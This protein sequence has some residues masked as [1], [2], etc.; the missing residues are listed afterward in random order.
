M[1][2][3]KIHAVVKETALDR[4]KER[5]QQMHVHNL[6]VAHVKGYGEHD[7]FFAFQSSHRYAWIEV[8]CE[9]PRADTIAQAVMETAHTGQPGDG[10]V[11]VLPIETMYRIRTKAEARPED[12]RGGPAQ[13]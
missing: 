12:F 8:F 6:T 13:E 1:P 7:E 4:V 11:A 3:K 2:Y 10:V 5:L 9:T